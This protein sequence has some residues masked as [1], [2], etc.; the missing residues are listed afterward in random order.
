MQTCFGYFWAS[1]CCYA[2]KDLKD[3]LLAVV[4]FYLHVARVIATIIDDQAKSVCNVSDMSS[5]S[6]WHIR[7]EVTIR[8]AL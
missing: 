1:I 6:S 4:N 8:S 3:A 2:I 5:V 7:M